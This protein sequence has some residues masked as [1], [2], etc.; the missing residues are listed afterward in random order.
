MRDY[1]GFSTRGICDWRFVDEEEVP[2][3]PWKLYGD[4][5]PFSKQRKGAGESARDIE[6]IVKIREMRDQYINEMP[7]AR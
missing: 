6:Q 4:N 5:N 7:M 3:G 1:L 2:D